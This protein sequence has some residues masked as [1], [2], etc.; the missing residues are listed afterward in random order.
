M[1]TNIVCVDD[2]TIDCVIH[3]INRIRLL[4]GMTW[5]EFSIALRY[6]DPNKTKNGYGLGSASAMYGAFKRAPKNHMHK[7]ESFVCRVICLV[8]VIT[9][10]LLKAN[11]MDFLHFYIE[12]MW[13][14]MREIDPDTLYRVRVGAYY[15]RNPVIIS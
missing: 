13:R 3:N 15:P 7:P 11:E 5:K 4:C 8:T 10:E 12:E 14:L 1:A 6:S 2:R 9:T